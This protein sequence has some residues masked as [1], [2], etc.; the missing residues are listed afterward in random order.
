MLN[1]THSKIVSLEQL[2]EIVHGV[3]KQGLRV[4]QSHGV[5]D[6]VHPGVTEH[7][8][9]ARQ[10]GDLLVVTVIRDRNVRRG[11]GRPVFPD[12]LR[13]RNVASLEM[14]DHVCIVDDEVP[15]ESV[16]NIQPD[17][18][19]KG[20]G[21]KDRDAA[22]HRKI[23]EEEKELYL[24]KCKV[25]Q[26]ESAPVSS[27]GII[28]N[29]LDIYSEDTKA[30]IRTFSNRYSFDDVCRHLDA[31]KDLK[32]LLIGDGIID[33]YCYCTPMGKSAKANLV[34]NRYNGLEVF[35]GGV[36]AI[37]NHIASICDQVTL[38][39]LLG[40]EGFRESF[41]RD[42]LKPNIT[43]RFFFRDDGSTVIKRR[44]IDSALN[45][46]LFEINFLS[47]NYIKGKV[48]QAILAFLEE[49]LQKYDLVL[50]SDFGHG[51]ITGDIIRI[52]SDNSPLTAVNSQTNGA[53]FGYNFIT[54]Y[55]GPDMICLDETEARLATQEKFAAIEDVA[56]ELADK[57]SVKCLV[58]TLGRKGSIALDSTGSIVR[59][60]VLS[61]RV[62]DTVGAGDAF[63][64]YSA[65]CYAAGMPLD[66]VSFIGNAVGALAVQI[67]GNKKSV[68]KYELLEY[69]RAILA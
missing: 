23:F 52:I 63:F 43:Q 30:Y 19:A 5:F 42:N 27:T 38:V 69:V 12:E 17:V 56:R 26:T 11:P 53:N 50:V 64:S 28:K 16:R 18:F 40:T 32:V 65:V 7:L 35:A 68:E 2:I 60:P 15:Y 61:S 6:L 66:L 9:L 45:Q 67:V 54:R 24:G 57:L 49:E 29:F 20:Q 55:I 25:F 47:E 39:T 34:V 4:V 13:A 8:A 33:E 36:F 48:E 46:K 31:L 59:T 14:V 58:V 22:M 51:F 21:H 37:A 44:Y 41:V 3:R 1:G 62:V 10:Q